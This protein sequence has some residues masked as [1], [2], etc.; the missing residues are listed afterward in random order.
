MINILKK[1]AKMDPK[2]TQGCDDIPS[3]LLRLGASGISS[4]VSQLVNH[5]VHVC[6]FPDTMKLADV[7]SLYKKNDN[8]RKTITGL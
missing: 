5:C 2:K 3:K 4:Y 1:Y 8:L 7:S 6:E